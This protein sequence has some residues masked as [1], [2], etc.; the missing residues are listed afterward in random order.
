VPGG[1]FHLAVDQHCLQCNGYSKKN[2]N[3]MFGVWLD[4]FVKKGKKPDYC[5]LCSSIMGFMESQK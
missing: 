5:R 3:T 2:T 1:G 4:K